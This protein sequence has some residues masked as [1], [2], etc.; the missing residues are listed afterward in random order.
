MLVNLK[1][2]FLSGGDNSSYTYNNIILAYP[3][4]ERF[5]VALLP[6]EELFADPDYVRKLG[7]INWNDKR[8][9]QP[10]SSLKKD[11]DD[12]RDTAT[13]FFVVMKVRI[14]EVDSPTAMTSISLLSRSP[15]TQ[16][17]PRPG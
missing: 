10:L 7:H 17:R 9:C 2:Q 4:D 3:D 13:I 5:L 15:L 16:A 6:I 8:R 11:L 12:D 1:I 14:Y